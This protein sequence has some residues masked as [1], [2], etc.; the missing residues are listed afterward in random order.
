MKTPKK[1]GPKPVKIDA[2]KLKAM[3]VAQ[4]YT[5]KEVSILAHYHDR[6][7]SRCLVRGSMS[8]QGVE[9]LEKLGFRRSRY[10]IK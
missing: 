10:V 2:L 1:R 6:W 9:Q 5:L 8:Q 4:D 3:I 7:L